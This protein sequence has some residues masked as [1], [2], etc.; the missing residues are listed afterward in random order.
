MGRGREQ[1]REKKRE[2]KKREGCG[3]EKVREREKGREEESGNSG[4]NQT[5]TKWLF[6]TIFFPQSLTLNI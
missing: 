2:R 6:Y 1:R 3:R 4:T 5:D